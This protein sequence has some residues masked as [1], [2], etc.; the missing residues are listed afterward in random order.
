M[1]VPQRTST[2]LRRG[3][4]GLLVGGVILAM[5]LVEARQDHPGD[6]RCAELWNAPANQANRSVV[7]GHSFPLATVRGVAPNKAG[8]PGCSVLLR[9][10]EDGRWLW[11]GAAFVTETSVVWD[12]SV[13]GVRYGTDSPT[14]YVDDTPNAN[15]QPDGSLVLR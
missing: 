13:S 7:G 5:V 9:E 3:A 12:G 2:V 6:G 1:P 8:Q 15:L 14:G 4:V 10:R 11:F